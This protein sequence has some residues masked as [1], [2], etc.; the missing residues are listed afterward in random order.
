MSDEKVYEMLWDC[1]YCGTKKLL[2]KTHRFCPNC[3]A[4]QDDEARYFPSDADKV[5]VEDHVYVGADL[6]CPSCDTLNAANS[7]FCQQCGTPLKGAKSAQLVQDDQVIGEGEHF[8]S[9]GSRNVAQERWEKKLDAAGLSPKKPTNRV[10]RRGLILGLGL[11][12]LILLV[13]LVAIFWKRETT[14]YVTAHNWTREI[15][16]ESYEAR[17]ESAWC[18]SMPGDAYSITRH[19]EQR[20]SKQIPDGQDCHTVRR[21]NG[22]G[23]YSE[24][25]QCTTRYRSEPIYDDRC[26]YTV[27]R[28][29]YE[30]S[31]SASGSSLGESPVW[32]SLKLGQTGTCLG[33][34]R[35]GAHEEHYIVTLRSNDQ[36]YTCDLSQDEWASM[37]IESLWTFKVGVV[38]NRPD[39]GSLQP[40]S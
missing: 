12:G 22:D 38:T 32:P 28:W 35:E 29:G 26:Y 11:V 31:V 19:Q 23:T 14:A 34:E 36:E 10:G 37:P 20:G 5:A 40:A 30:R 3:G 17:S 18:D 2:G 8:E 15:N 25:Q 16:I 1:K 13:V 6:I 39:C 21:D 27:N 24:S 4:P 9:T 7:E 33:C